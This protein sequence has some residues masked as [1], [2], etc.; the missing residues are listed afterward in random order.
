[1]ADIFEDRSTGLESPGFH[2]AEVIPSDTTDLAQT[3]RALFIGM[4]G[5]LRVTM[6]GDEIV[7]FR[8][9][10]AGTLPIRA[11]RIH[12]TGTTAADIVAIW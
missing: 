11:R 6:A 3:S 8:N 1:M 7:T 2:A 10:S 12:A 9:V 4:G 5:N